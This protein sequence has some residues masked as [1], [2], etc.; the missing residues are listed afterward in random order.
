MQVQYPPQT[1]FICEDNTIK[2]HDICLDT[3]QNVCQFEIHPSGT[4]ETVIT[5]VGVGCVCLRTLCDF[6]QVDD[7]TIDTSNHSN[8]CICN[9]VSLTGCDLSCTAPVTTI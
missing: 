5:Y 2:A 8:S 3:E 9:F 7:L 6:V 4:P 1:G